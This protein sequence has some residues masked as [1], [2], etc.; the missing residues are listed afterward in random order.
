MAEK[1][2]T[3][4][5]TLQ[6]AVDQL[7]K[8]RQDHA[9]AIDQIDRGLDDLREQINRLLGGT[10]QPS[11][12]RKS[13]GNKGTSIIV[14]LLK[15]AKGKMKSSDLRLAAEEQGVQHPH[16]SLQSLKRRGVIE[17]SNG[18]VKLK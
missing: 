13:N 3:S 11:K 15:N 5:S 16:S 17:L 1:S 6:E 7:Q 4:I 18:T 14:E 12:P 10:K 8:E 9:T 2:Q